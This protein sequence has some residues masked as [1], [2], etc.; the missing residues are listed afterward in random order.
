MKKF[1]IC[2]TFIVT[3]FLFALQAQSYKGLVEKNLSGLI[4]QKKIS[5]ND[6]SSWIAT[7][8]NTSR[9]SGVQNVYFRQSLDGLEIYGTESSVHVLSNGKELKSYNNFV[10]DVAQKSTSGVNPTKTAIQAVQLAASHLGYSITESLREIS[11]KNTI[12]QETIVSKGGIS[13]SE[14]PVKLMYQKLDNGSIILVWNLSI[15]SNSK[16]EWYSINVNAITGEIVNKGNWITSCNFDHKHSGEEHESHVV[17]GPMNKRKAH[18][19]LLLTGSYEV[20]AQPLENPLYGDRTIVTDAVNTVA[21]PYGWHD[22]N[23]VAGAEYTVTQGNNVDA[24]KYGGS[25]NGYQPDGGS[26][27]VF[28]YPFNSNYTTGTPYMDASLTNLFYWNNI[29]H[30]VLYQYGFDE[31]SGNF[32]QNNYGNGGAGNDAVQAQGQ[33]GFECNAYF[34]T[35]PD[36]SAGVMQMYICSNKDGSYDN[37]VMVHEYGHGISN[38]LTGGP[39]NADCL[40]NG[41]Q[42][43]EGWSDWYGLML[44]MDADDEPTDS[45]GIGTYLFGEP[46]GGGGIREYP[47]STNMTVNPHTYD[48][49]KNEWGPHG[50]GS[51]WAAMLWEMTWALIDEYGFDEDFYNGDGGNNIALAL[52]TEGLRL[53]P[54]SPGFVDGRD[55]ILAADMALY[56]GANQCLIWEAFAKRGLGVSA[57][58]GSSGNNT[59][60]TEAFDSPMTSSA[61]LNINEQVCV[62]EGII[63][64]LGGGLPA[65]GV[66]SGL[67]VTD[68]GNG[69]T[70]T[71]DTDVAG[72]GNH[73]ITY[74]VPETSCGPG[75]TDTD[76][77]EVIESLE[78]T[79]PEDME[80]LIAEGTT[81]TVP[82]YLAMGEIE[83]I[84]NCEN[85]GVTVIQTPAPETQL[86]EGNH[87]IEFEI[88]DEY[89][90]IVNCSF[91][92][93]IDEFLGVNEYSLNANSVKLFPN[94]T[95]DNVT[96][97]NKSSVKIDAAVL[98]DASGRLIQ[99]LNWEN[100]KEEM[101]ISL[102]SLAPGVYFV[103]LNSDKEE[104]IKSVIKK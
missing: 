29:I 98:I 34:G 27:L 57:T 8:E 31:V 77:L 88:M 1:T 6:A 18:S 24:F 60:G 95:T 67:G 35:P 56:G 40:W 33:M 73:T 46:A 78:V 97:V 11:R 65:G 9:T 86:G 30:D 54:C 58:Q 23:G 93:V 26:S 5:K 62:S 17:Y 16:S 99:K 37:L 49:I 87:T 63:T 55:A 13:L 92:L 69:T 66:Y 25:S 48:D 36:G 2:C 47:Y 82:D 96:I 72:L 12:S 21:S 70:F 22:T 71:F 51:I 10:K 101:T 64:G 42:M 100:G 76:V 19:S 81:F 4:S 84:S 80:E 3:A 79:C 61:N 90:N 20:F 41:E 39:A 15:Q 85:G 91:E 14:I 75:S 94:P 102:K 45:R 53:Q 52:V 89:D 50:I 38:R 103:K 74:S 68:N 43:G 44:S 83:V 28:H 32:Q 7:S 59:D 104:I